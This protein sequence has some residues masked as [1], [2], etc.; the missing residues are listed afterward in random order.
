MVGIGVFLGFLVFGVVCAAAGFV[1]GRGR[2]AVA[3]EQARQGQ[4]TV[5]RVEAER[6]A[7]VQ[8][9]GVLQQQFQ[10]ATAARAGLEA[11]LAAEKQRSAEQLAMVRDEQQQVQQVTA[12][13]LRESGPQ[14]VQRV[15][16]VVDQRDKAAVRDLDQRK[17]AIEGMI[18]PLIQQLE[19]ITDHSQ[20]IEKNRVGAYEVLTQQV[21]AMSRAN[22]ELR[23]ETRLLVTALRRPNTRGQWGERQLRNVVE[24]AGMLDQVD[25]LEQQR[26]ETT[27]GT[28]RP[29]MLVKVG[30]GKTIVVDA[31]APFSAFL[32]A[33]DAR[34]EGERKQRLSA[35]AGHV[36]RHVEQLAAKQYWSAL[37]CTPEFVVM[38]LPTEAFL[39]AAEDQDPSLWEFAARNNV[40]LATPTNLLTLLRTVALIWRQ[41]AIAENT[42]QVMEHG[43]ELHKRLKTMADHFEALGKR[44]SSAAEYYDKTIGS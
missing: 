6:D 26:L 37:P 19:K 12:A 7:A 15:T 32:E 30:G 3:E 27:E 34:D 28:L 22:K 41:E 40:L 11:E 20:A 42:Q 25:F 18:A 44:I 23:E 35:H 31:K 16:E 1:V 13:V 43:R 10:D 17:T 9:I 2:L 14:L 38:F 36:R 21:E 29:D 39:Y 4:K 33:Q 24:A 8:Q 5:E